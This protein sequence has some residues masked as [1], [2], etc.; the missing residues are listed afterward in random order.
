MKPIKVFNDVDF[1]A[2]LKTFYKS[3]G[4]KGLVLRGRNANRKQFYPEENRVVTCN[5]E[6]W[7]QKSVYQQ[8]LPARFATHFAVYGDIKLVRKAL[9]S[10]KLVR[11]VD[12]EVRS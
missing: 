2:F 12:M 1:I 4:G 9:I 6:T 7:T 5:G 11:D 8:D 10:W 3:S